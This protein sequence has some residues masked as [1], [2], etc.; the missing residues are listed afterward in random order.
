MLIGQ[1]RFEMAEQEL[2]RLLG[3]FPEHAQAHAMLAVCLTR[4]EQKLVEATESA[5]KAVMLEPDEPYSHY[6]H[7]LV[8]WKRNHFP[9]AQAAIAEAIRLNPYDA[10]YFAQS[11]PVAS[12]DSR[13][14]CVSEG[15]GIGLGR[16]PRKRGLQ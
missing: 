15:C 1:G 13:L 8:R 2:R 10:D 16:R 7:S 12:V 3:E 6:I 9:E 5:Q 14:E 4:D 11:S